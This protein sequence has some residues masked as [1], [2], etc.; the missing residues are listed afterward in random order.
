MLT[1]IQCRNVIPDS[2][3]KAPIGMFH[4]GRLYTNSEPPGLRIRMHSESQRLHQSRYS[5]SDRLSFT[6]D[7]YFFPRLNGGSAKTVS[8]TPSRICGKMARQS[9]AYNCPRSE[10]K[11]G[12]ETS[13]EKIPSGF[14]SSDAVGNTK[15]FWIVL[16]FRVILEPNPS[17]ETAPIAVSQILCRGRTDCQQRN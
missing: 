10:R 3:R 12:D 15:V 11:C 4:F 13:S 16:A 17:F 6:F 2:D 9:S 14:Q 8:I 7:P 1:E 5:A